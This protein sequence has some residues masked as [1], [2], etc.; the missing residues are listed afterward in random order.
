VRRPGWHRRRHTVV[1]VVIRL[2]WGRKV[3]RVG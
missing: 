1:R 2:R 3:I